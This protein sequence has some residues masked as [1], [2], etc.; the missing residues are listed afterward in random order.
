LQRDGVK[1]LE[2]GVD[3]AVGVVG[4]LLDLDAVQEEGADVVF[5]E[6]GG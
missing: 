6:F 1:E 5:A 3:L 4:D 2:G